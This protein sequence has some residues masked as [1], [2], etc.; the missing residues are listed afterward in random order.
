M[1]SQSVGLTRRSILRAGALA[2]VLPAAAPAASPDAPSSRSGFDANRVPF[3]RSASY[4]AVSKRW[5]F[6]AT[7]EIPAGAWYI[8]LLADDVSPNELF[9]LEIR[10]QQGA[11]PFEGIL[12]PAKLTLASHESA[13]DF[14]I[15]ESDVLRLRGRD[16]SLRMFGIKGSYGYAIAHPDGSW[17]VMAGVSMPRVRIHTTSGSLKVDAPWTDQLHAA[18]CASITV[19]L[20]PDES[21]EFDCTLA[22]YDATPRPFRQQPFDDCV[23]K[24]QED[25]TGWL[26]DLPALSDDYRGS[27]ELAAYVLWSATVAP[28]GLYKTSV[29]WCSKSWMNRIWSWDHCFVAIGLAPSH[30]ELAWQQ[31]MLVRDMQDK[32]SGMFCDSFT[33]VRRSWLCTKPPIHGWA[34]SHLMRSMSLTRPQLSESYELL[35]GWTKFWLSQR[36]FDDDG[37]PCILNANE[38]FDNT[39]SNTLF[40]PVKA[41][42]IA[43]YLVLQMEVLGKV[44]GK[45]GLQDDAKSWQQKSAALLRTMIRLLWDPYLGKFVARRV[46]DGKSGEGDCVYSYVPLILGRRLPENIIRPLVASVSDGSRFFTPFGMCTE[47]LKSPRYNG[48]TYVKGPVWAPPTVFIAEG[49]EQ[50]GDRAAASRL[51]KGFLDNCVRQGMSEHFDARSGAAQGDP[52]YNW[53]AAMF[54]HFARLEQA[55]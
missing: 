19:D 45:L 4:W 38:S 10:S 12:T 33:N 48:K 47:S 52:A 20:V 2:P 21:G 14:S 34:L 41:P 17:E 30:P 54:L 46:G 53:T 42:E 49:L 15:P 7:Q 36:N 24:A 44:A 50:V 40:A 1:N 8:R 51:R 23:R 37:L 32:A 27:R 28:R 25:F 13:V 6:G 9:R 5:D 26:Q 35:T 29:V 11:L 43:A 31:F 18:F 3:S 39:T 55:G 16:C 22:Y